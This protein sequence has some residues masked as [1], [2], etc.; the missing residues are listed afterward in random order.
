MSKY[1]S[2]QSGKSKMQH[3][4]VKYKIT[5]L[6]S[7]KTSDEKVFED[8]QKAKEHQCYINYQNWYEDNK[9]YG[10]YAGSYANFDDLVEWL[11]ENEN[12]VLDI[13]GIVH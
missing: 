5:E 3:E 8:E 12:V 6:I 13:L 9:L 7:Y 2:R 11:K 10:N 4:Y 1:S